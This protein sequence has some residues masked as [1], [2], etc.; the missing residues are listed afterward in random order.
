MEVL[1]QA[2]AVQVLAIFVCEFIEMYWQKGNSVLNVIIYNFS[3]Y[4]IKGIFV[5]IFMHIDFILIAYLVATVGSN[6]LW[7]I[8]ALKTADLGYKFYLLD[9]IANKRVELNPTMLYALSREIGL[10]KYLGCVIYPTT[11]LLLS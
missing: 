3:I 6:A 5:Y 7:V 11:L 2:L 10:F 1:S 8:F 4:R 9:K